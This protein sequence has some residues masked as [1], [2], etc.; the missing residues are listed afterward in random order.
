VLASFTLLRGGSALVLP[1]QQFTA[2]QLHLENE[3]VDNVSF[4]TEETRR[5]FIGKAFGLGA[6]T[7]GLVLSFSPPAYAAPK[8]EEIDKANIVKGYKRLQYLLDNWEKETT[9]CGMGGDKLERSCDRTPMKVMEY[10]GYK[11]TTDPLYKAEKTLRR[12]YENAPPKRDGEFID[13]VEAF[14]ENADEA[15]GMAF[16]S[17]W[18]EANPGGGKDRVELFIERAKKNVITSRNSLKTVIDILELDT[19]KN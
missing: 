9:V 17:S 6:A 15:S 4:V 1:D 3:N 8:Q 11:S 7:T 10:M 14:A 5:G 2:S 16:I 19:S 12:L 18:G 13:A